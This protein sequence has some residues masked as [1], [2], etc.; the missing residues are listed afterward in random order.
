MGKVSNIGIP[1]A[2]AASLA[3]VI[4]ACDGSGSGDTGLVP[5]PDGNG[6]VVVFDPLVKPTPEIPFPN[7][8]VTTRDKSSPTGRRLNVSAFA[9][10]QFE[11]DVRGHLDNLDGFGTFASIT[12]AFDKAI[13][14]ATATNDTIKL[15]NLNP[16][17]PNYGRA[18]SLDLGAGNF[19]V[20]TDR[21]GSEPGGW[22][23][24][25][26]HHFR[27]AYTFFFD[28]MYEDVGLDG[29]ENN[30]EPG[31][32]PVDNPD[33]SGDNYDPAAKEGGTE[34]NGRIDSEDLNGNG[35]LDPGED[36]DGDDILDHEPDY[37]RD[38][39]ADRGNRVDLDGN[40]ILDSG[41]DVNCNHRWDAGEVDFDGDGRLDPCEFVDFYEVETDTLML[42]P[43]IPMEEATEYAVVLTRG[44][45]GL[46]PDGLPGGG[47]AVRSPFPFVNH[48]AQTERL[49]PLAELLPGMGLALDD[50]AFAWTFTTQTVTGLLT[51]IRNGLYG[52]G[53][54]AYLDDEVPTTLGSVSDLGITF[55]G[56]GLC[57]LLHPDNLDNVHILQ[58]ERLNILLKLILPFIEL[59]KR[60]TGFDHL[61]LDHLDYIVLGTF[62]TPY[63]RV[64][65]DEIFD[66]D[67]N[68]GRATYEIGD[69]TFAIFV[70]KASAEHS[71]PF[72]V[73]LYCH[74]NQSFRLEAISVAEAFAEHGIA[75]A[76]IDAVGHGPIIS[77]CELLDELENLGD[78]WLQRLLL[79]LIARIFG[80]EGEFSAMEPMEILDTILEEVGFLREI[81]V[82]GRAVDMDGDEPY[83]C[84]DNGE[85]FWTADTFKTRDVIRQTV[86]DLMQFLRILKSM[87]ADA[88]PPA[89]ERPCEA[90][91]AELMPN[92][93]AGD[94]NADGV[95]D[96]GGPD[97]DYFQTG[98]S[99]GGIISSIVMGIEPDI[100]TGAPVVPGAGFVD[101]M[102]RSTLR[103]VM[104]RIYF[105]VLGPLVEARQYEAGGSVNLRW[106]S[107]YETLE[108]DI[109]TIEIPEG[110]SL[111]V[112]NLDN[113]E[114]KKAIFTR[115]GAG[116]LF[117]T[118]GIPADI[119]DYIEIHVYDA[120]GEMIDSASTR[121]TYKGFGLDRNTPDFRRFFSLAQI[122]LEPGDPIN[123]A[124]H[125]FIDP[126][127]GHP[128]K[129]ILQQSDPGD[130]TLPI[131]NQIA[132]ARA[133]G[134]FG[135]DDVDGNE[136]NLC[137]GVG[138]LED[139]EDEAD[140][141]DY[142]RCIWADCDRVNFKL[143]EKGVMLGFDSPPNEPR[144]DVDEM[145][146]FCEGSE[147]VYPDTR[148][149]IGPLPIITNDLGVSAI[150]FPFAGIH[151][152]FGYY[153][154]NLEEQVPGTKIYTPH[155]ARRVG[156]FFGARGMSIGDCPFTFEEGPDCD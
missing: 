106:I 114:I 57:G 70:P 76:A 150:R 27:S 151:E 137:D 24:P 14:L 69:V 133:G 32:H 142:R 112:H 46:G 77:K 138:A 23:F 6:P 126:L 3:L 140:P 36:L 124:P 87:D 79:G 37:D 148:E 80:V 63:F 43:V 51:E 107:R 136:E 65:D 16:D 84:P 108:A 103:P 117:F 78:P 61:K 83:H 113:D 38:G 1:I 95:L 125:W 156:C 73:S 132:L 98:I 26:N 47:E 55:D 18:V 62:P 81:L 22:D 101:V 109:G 111:E 116:R 147:G 41:E 2:F 58:A 139:C 120:D 30:R 19:P 91:S 121:A 53:P 8:L 5:T 122:T 31:F 127:P 89:V 104:N 99:L 100:V 48:A 49:A 28:P 149:P 42:R 64:T 66:I 93:L 92:L 33:P 153:D 7:D 25:A 52:E 56:R 10:T 9:P 13:D 152:F 118:V 75:V 141:M 97:V 4:T 128:Q 60:G 71:P 21:S 129:N 154:T 35:I 20:I 68:T 131:N 130:F 17:S 145:N 39:I 146:H 15:I 74:G 40:G 135:C 143:R 85:N 54:F 59:D 45:T 67:L 44:L 123:Y 115:D 72:P 134:L 88:I 119:G 82:S 29:I 96:L 12:V 11:E 155:S 105:Q 94:F 34:G 50:V 110:A 90:S 102:L 144:Y 86:I